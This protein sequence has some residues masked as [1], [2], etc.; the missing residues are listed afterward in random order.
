MLW[1]FHPPVIETT[2]K[3]AVS[4]LRMLAEHESL[5]FRK[6]DG[7]SFEL[8]MSVQIADD[9]DTVLL[10]DDQVVFLVA[11]AGSPER[12]SALGGALRTQAN[13]V[14]RNPAMVLGERVHQE[15][16]RLLRH[17]HGFVAQFL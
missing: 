8:G 9:P 16:E 11:H 7:H 5:V 17:D 14:R 6:F 2:Y 15:G 1:G 12:V 13:R 10:E 4:V 3:E